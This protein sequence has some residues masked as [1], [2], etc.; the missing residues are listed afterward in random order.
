MYVIATLANKKAY[1][2]I[3]LFLYTLELWNIELPTVY[4]ACDHFIKENVKYKGK[5]VFF[6]QLNA[7]DNLE[8]SVMEKMAGKYTRTLW[9]DLMCEKIN[10]LELVHKSE[11]KVLLC[12]ADICFMG[13]LPE[14]PEHVD[15]GL[16]K[17][18]IRDFDEHLY[19]IYNGGFVFSGNSNIPTLW[20]EATKTSRYFEQAALES[21]TKDLQVHYFPKSCNYGWWRLLQGKETS[22]VLEKQWKLFRNPN[23]CGI[24]IDDTPLASI[25]T[26]FDTN[27]IFTA[28]FNNFVLNLLN[29][30]TSLDKTKKLINFLKKL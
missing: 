27:D 29:K 23:N 9:E 13:P 6:E 26:H 30:L 1:K 25:H 16:S 5:I 17:H 12:D 28:Y 21:L 14:V 19:G 2:D 11:N 4:I 22:T 15:I 10:L 24:Y 8:R 7:Y 3:Q 20:K 18:E